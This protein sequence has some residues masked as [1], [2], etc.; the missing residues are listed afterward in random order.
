MKSFWIKAAHEKLV[1]EM[2]WNFQS[3]ASFYYT[4]KERSHKADSNSNSLYKLWGL[5]LPEP[6]SNYL[7]HKIVKNKANDV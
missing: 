2:E 6:W 7:T 3:S 5:I 1:A 4:P